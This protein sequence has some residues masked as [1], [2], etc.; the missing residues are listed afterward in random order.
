[1]S[2]QY[3]GNQFMSRRLVEVIQELR[4]Y[5]GPEEAHGLSDEEVVHLIRSVGFD[6]SGIIK[7]TDSPRLR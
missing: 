5:L 2:Y 3:T 4:D 6:S 7:G 1:M